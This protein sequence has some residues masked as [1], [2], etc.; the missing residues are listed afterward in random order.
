MPVNSRHPDYDESL[1]QWKRCRDVYD[2]TDAVKA[3][4]EAYL[5]RAEG[6]SQR[7]YQA[8]KKR[9]MLFGAFNRTVDG[10]VGSIA[11]KPPKLTVP[12]KLRYIEDDIT[13]TGIGLLEFIKMLAAELLTPGR[14]GI[15]T[16]WDDAKGRPFLSMYR[17]EQIINWFDG[18]EAVIEEV[19]TERD[20]ADPFKVSAVNQW[21]HLFLNE[22]GH[23]VINKYRKKSG[24]RG[25]EF[26]LASTETPTKHNKPF[27][28]VPFKFI[29]RN[30]ATPK[31]DKPP[32]IDLADVVLAHYMNSADL[33]HGAHQTALPTLFISGMNNQSQPIYV[34]GDSA[35]ILNDPQA[36]VGY[37][38]FSGDGLGVLT[39]MME[40]KEHQMAVLGA[41]LLGGGKA[42][43][44]A[45]ET[46]RI[47]TSGETSLLSGIVSAIEEVLESSLKLMADWL[48][49]P[50]EVDLHINRDFVGSRLDPNE[51]TAL[52]KA[53]VSNAIT[54]EAFLHN[55]QE[56]EMLGPEMTIEDQA[57]EIRS[58]A[59]KQAAADHKAAADALALKG[60]QEPTEQ[61]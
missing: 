24:P 54:L 49:A 2:G 36:K 55:L 35:I 8:Y 21:C 7:D 34:G 17:A 26:A 32:L 44:E 45:A 18:N 47:R 61:Q 31:I 11:R 58:A 37:A 42:G 13:G 16:E 43:V 51:L 53:Y 6:Q 25:Q 15:L 40:H 12:E 60:R 14:T 57:A 59:E 56:G 1:E 38:E 5:P 50:G 10:F 52:V 28:E 41:Q 33:E 20:P 4:G 19:I 23:Y 29:G 9:A 30:G 46:A 27:T 39:K 22:E 3:A 48:S